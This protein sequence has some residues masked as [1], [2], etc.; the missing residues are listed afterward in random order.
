MSRHDL[1][2]KFA[3]TRCGHDQHVHNLIVGC[4]HCKC[5]ASPSEAGSDREFAGQPKPYAGHVLAPTTY[6]HEWQRPNPR[7][8]ATTGPDCRTAGPASNPYW[9]ATHRRE[10]EPA[11]TLALADEGD[12]LATIHESALRAILSIAVDAMTSMTV[13]DL[14]ALDL[15][16]PYRL[17]LIG[18]ARRLIAATGA[19][20]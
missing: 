1:R 19:V 5:A 18:D 6:L 7:P 3:C 11:R 13:A 10:H 8:R 9:C 17:I 15:P 4:P 16:E 2:G 20:S 12:L 14:E